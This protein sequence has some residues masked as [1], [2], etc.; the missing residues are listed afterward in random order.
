MDTL[1]VQLTGFPNGF[2]RGVGGKGMNDGVKVLAKFLGQSFGRMGDQVGGKIRCL[3]SD[4]LSR[5]IE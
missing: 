4:M 2:G 3:V 5:A 1:K